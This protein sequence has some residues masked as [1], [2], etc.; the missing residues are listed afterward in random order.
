MASNEIVQALSDLWYELA[1]YDPEI[2]EGDIDSAVEYYRILP[3][4]SI[5]LINDLEMLRDR[6]SKYTDV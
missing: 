6:L 3:S 2:S 5:L 1:K 4:T